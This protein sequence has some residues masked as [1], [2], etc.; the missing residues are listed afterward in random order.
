MVLAALAIDL[1][2]SALGLV[3]ETRPSIESITERGIALN[4]TAVLN[5]VFTLVGA[6][7][8]WLTIRRGFTDPACG[9]RVDRYQTPHRS[10][11]HGRPVYFCS[12][13]CKERFDADPEAYADRLGGTL[14]WR[15]RGLLSWRMTAQHPDPGAIEQPP[16][17]CGTGPCRGGDPSWAELRAWMR[18]RTRP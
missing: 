5:L 9:M 10:Q 7:L 12:A 6:T 16:P 1:L 17:R 15:P 13:G 2:F 14:G 8:L 4:Y 18:R 3:P 11:W